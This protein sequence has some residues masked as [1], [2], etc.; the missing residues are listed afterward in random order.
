MPQESYSSLLTSIVDPPKAELVNISKK[1]VIPTAQDFPDNSDPP[2]RWTSNK[3]TLMA[4]R[5]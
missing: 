5:T 3:N 2:T 4:N 1:I